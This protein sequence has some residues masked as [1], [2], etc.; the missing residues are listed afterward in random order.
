MRLLSMAENQKVWGYICGKSYAGLTFAP[1]GDLCGTIPGTTEAYYEYLA[2]AVA[3]KSKSLT[4]TFTIGGASAQI[5][6]PLKTPDDVTAF[7]EMRTRV[8]SKIDCTKL[9]LPSG[10]QVPHFN[11]IKEGGPSQEC[12]DDY[13]TF[14]PREQIVAEGNI[15]RNN[16]QTAQIQ[17]VGLVS[18]LGLRGSGTIVAGGVNQIHSWAQSEHCASNET[19]FNTCATKLKAALDKDVLFSEVR[20]YFRSNALDIGNFSYNTYAAFPE[21]MGI[22][23]VHG[24]DGAWDLEKGL[25]T[26]CSDNNGV[27]FGYKG[28]NSCMKALFTSLYITSFFERPATGARQKGLHSASSLSYE[29]SAAGWAKGF[30]EEAEA[31]KSV[32]RQSVPQLAT[33]LLSIPFSGNRRSSSFFEGVRIHHNISS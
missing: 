12:I 19:S 6:I 28:H 5:A 13:I 10:E 21:A 1:A 16:I 3:G 32:R 27:R 18:F 11:A 7:K 26:K 31:M 29:P 22:E 20:E 33:S 24:T 9:Q 25:T 14:R 17:G 8:A 30:I 15:E 23:H 2:N 4:G